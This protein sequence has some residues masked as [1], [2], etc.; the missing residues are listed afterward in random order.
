ME[1]LE[2]ERREVLTLI[3]AASVRGEGQSESLVHSL[4]S[5]S[6]IQESPRGQGPPTNPPLYTKH[7]RIINLI[8]DGGFHYVFT[9]YFLLCAHGI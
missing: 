4:S 3:M 6:R 2:G 1:L 8:I 5:L 9:N 7:S